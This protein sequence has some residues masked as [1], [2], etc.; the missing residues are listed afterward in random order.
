MNR[1]LIG[2]G[3]AL[4]WAGLALIGAL[5][6]G[7]AQGC[8]G[9]GKSTGGSTSSSGTGMSTTTGAGGGSVTT[10]TSAVSSTST[11]MQMMACTTAA[12]GTTRGSAI[13]ITSDDSRIITVNRDAGSVTVMSVD[14]SMTPP[15]VATVKELPVGAEPY[16][17]A[18][19]GCDDTAYVVLRKDQKLVEI[20]GLKTTPAVGRTVAVGSEPT[21]LAI[22][23]HNSKIYVSNWVDGTLTVVDPFMMAVTGTIDLNT[24][25]AA[26]GALG[27][28]SP[29]AALAHPRGLAITNHNMADDSGESVLATEWYAVRTGPESAVGTA[30][31][32]NWKGLLYE[33]GVATGTAKTIDLPSVVDTGFQ[34]VKGQTTGCFPNQVASVT[35]DAGFAY[36]TSTCAS[37]VGPVGVVQ[38]GACTT[39]AQCGAFPVGSVCSNTST[40][41]GG[42]CTLSC[43]S[44]AE[45]GK[46]AAAG[47]CV[48][49][50]GTCKP[51][52]ENAK[53][54][55]H[56]GLTIV[57]LSSGSATTSALDNLFFK[58]AGTNAFGFRSPLLPS[59]VGFHGT[60]AYVTGEG[61]DAAF[62]L[63]ITNGTIASVGSANNNFI[64][65]RTGTD[66]TIR[67][68]IGIAM[69]NNSA[70]A[71]VNNDGNR[72]VTVVDLSAQAVGN[73]ATVVTTHSSALPT[74]G[75]PQASQLQGKRLFTTGLGRWSL[76]G[77]GWGSC[78]ACHFEGL[79]DNVTWYFAR[80]PRQT[81][82]LDATYSK[83]DP[84]DQRIFNWNSIAD[85]MADLENNTRGISGGVGALVTVVGQPCTVATQVA[86]CG[87]TGT[88]NATTLICQP[89]TKDRINTFATNPPQTGL[90]GSS[91]DTANPMGAANPHTVLN[92][93][94]DITNWTKTVRTPL[95]PTNLVAADVA[96]GKVLFGAG[97]GNCV[98]CHSGS[99]WT[100]SQ[101]FYT[102]SNSFND[103]PPG[104]APHSLS[105]TSWN[106]SL[107]G[108]PAALFPTANNAL[109][110]DRVGGAP[111]FEQLG[112]SVR[113]VGT[114]GALVGGIP[115]GISPAAVGVIEVR[116]DMVTPAQGSGLVPNEPTA[117]FNVPSLLGLS[118]GAPY[119]HA[120]NARTLEE[121]F[122][123]MFKGHYQSPVAS[124]FQPTSDQIRQLTAYLLSIDEN[125]PAV[126][127]PTKGPTGGVICIPPV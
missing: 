114:I 67:L 106:V 22:T 50:A 68:P 111:A 79:S 20:T 9:N 29:R 13:A 33:V 53:T 116:Q 118:V 26:T 11:G 73:A 88:C 110:F 95:K 5:A 70:F 87:A 78:G 90:Q 52:V 48:L 75:T 58:Q 38:K 14:N 56:P 61:A 107:G 41:G 122:D 81:I 77:Q 85:E 124:V 105:Q 45:C 31:D 84:T 40:A 82:S 59:D 121:T 4:T 54:T 16:Q 126:A 55:T 125:E 12:K 43:L 104:T 24:T 96:A 115:Q 80:G 117:G 51:Q 83:S 89:Q 28:A 66:K 7:M 18:I 98:G 94:N 62:R 44:D 113:P 17:V 6:A 127:I 10:S 2:R 23:P 71:Y 100:V 37:P 86:D 15:V 57:D 101:V 120:G 119:Y 27:T 49:P 97:Q 93:W 112:C 36:V 108:F 91:T 47:D 92:D 3:G 123:P 21:S 72:D 39:N 74:A 102:P 60:F 32:T 1:S 99:K 65:M 63:S 69:A 103:A 8:S 35:I 64:D 76:R 34:D 109:Q 19:N 46:L 25:I 42:V 30:S